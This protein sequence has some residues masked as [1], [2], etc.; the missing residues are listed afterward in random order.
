[1]VG[2]AGL[3]VQAAPASAYTI[4]LYEHQNGGGGY[5]GRWSISSN[6]DGTAF[7]NGVALNDHVSSLKNRQ[8][9]WTIFWTDAFCRGDYL[10][11][12][13]QTVVTYVGDGNDRFSSHAPDSYVNGC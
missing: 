13:P 4:D 7:N 8:Q 6:Y 10:P 3:L 5:A 9:N 2:L 11:V 1:V 12:L